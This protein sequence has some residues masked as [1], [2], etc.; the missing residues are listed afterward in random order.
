LSRLEQALAL[1]NRF[2]VFPIT[3]GEKSPPLISGWQN[4]ATSDEVRVRAW[5]AQWPDA[6][7]GIHC[8][9]L[10][11]I[12][13][14]PK[15]GG[16]ESLKALEKE[17]DLEAT[18]E[19]Q[20]PSGGRH[21]YYRA[22]SGSV[23]NGV[24]ILGPG[25][26]IRA[27]NGYVVAPSSST[28]SGSYT[29]YADE[30]IADADPA[31]IARCGVRPKE[32]P[33]SDIGIVTDASAAIERALDFLA[34][35]EPAFQGQGGDLHTFRTVCVLRDFGVPQN[36]VAEVMADWNARCSPPWESEALE[37]K[38]RNAYN[39]AQN[40]AGILSP[41][42]VG[43]EE[44]VVNENDSSQI[45][46]DD[47]V[48]LF[49]P[50]AVTDDEI[51]KVDYLIK[52]VLDREANAVLFGQWNVGK[53]FVVLDM[54]ACIASGTDWFGRR[55]K[56]GRVLYLGYEGIRA[57]KKRMR[58]LREKHTLLQIPTTPLEWA[59]IRKALTDP[60]G[61]AEANLI[62]KKFGRKHG[63]PPALIVID[64]LAAAL[65]GD[66]SDATLMEQLN[67]IVRELM[68]VYKCTVLRVHHSGHGN[69][70]RAR[71]H[72]SLPAGIDT[73]IRV[74]KRLIAL[75]KQ[76]DDTAEAF[77]WDL[78]TVEVGR[79]TDGDRVTTCVVRKVDSNGLARSEREVLDALLELDEELVTKT[80][81]NAASK[82]YPAT[83]RKAMFNKFIAL[84]FLRPEGKNFA[85]VERGIAASMFDKGE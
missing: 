40:Q 66:D 11:V 39:Y 5:W 13:V 65:G 42:G 41:E 33:V 18:Y 75:T 9:G 58:A 1:A 3:P 83:I 54:A 34:E 8:D 71:G 27:T 77:P 10:L 85:I 63:G 17:I 7:I 38:I 67:S 4:F 53:T 74:D 20:T 19:V 46:N 43:F 22:E 64:T 30:P 62:I 2:L 80:Q 50:S 48:E 16:Y 37:T 45:E 78:E 31:I 29:V 35:R 56:K 72:S 32:A 73:E 14:D 47:D 6:N 12:D 57:M 61:K 82:E 68:R 36:R 23:R 81:I 25:L 55:V 84:G 26:D 76:R 24:D 28:V 60:K 49:H 79:D 51:L 52:G 44:V 69:Q 59:P 15:K 70:E 21:L